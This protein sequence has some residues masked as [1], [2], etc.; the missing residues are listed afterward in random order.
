MTAMSTPAAARRHSR[1]FSAAAP[2]RLLA[3]LGAAW[4]CAGTGCTKRPAYSYTD[5]SVGV[6][7]SVSRDQLAQII[8]CE[9]QV[10][11]AE[12]SDV[13]GLRCPENRVMA[14]IGTFQWTSKVVTGTL[15][16]QVRVFDVN[17]IPLGEGTSDPVTLSPGAENHASIVVRW[18]GPPTG[19]DAGE[20]GSSD[21]G[22]D[23]GGDAADDGASDDAA[24]DAAADGA[25]PDSAEVQP[26]P[27]DAGTGDSSAG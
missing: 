3:L 19:T 2:S 8:S 6:D 25:S 22:S 7:S 17:H 24:T 1:R 26:D 13:I 12:T 20:D 9:L 23:D 27:S 4:L 10:T 18:L 21:A 14:N 11:G 15:Q 16:F 5:V